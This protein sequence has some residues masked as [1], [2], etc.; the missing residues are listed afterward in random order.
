MCLL[1]ASEIFAFGLNLGGELGNPHTHITRICKLPRMGR[2]SQV[3]A[4]MSY[5]V[6]LADGHPPENKELSVSAPYQAPPAAADGENHR[7]GDDNAGHVAVRIDISPA[8]PR[9][10]DHEEGAGGETEE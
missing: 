8:A 6:L 9:D 5:S 3:T 4:G 10:V 2:V 1:D 7:D